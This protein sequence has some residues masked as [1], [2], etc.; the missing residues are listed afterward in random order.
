M[1]YES[2]WIFY[3][4]IL[5]IAFGSIMSFQIAYG[6][7]LYG[8]NAETSIIVD[9]RGDLNKIEYKMSGMEPLTW[10]DSEVKQYKHG[11]FFLKNPEIVIFGHPQG[12]DEYLL[13]VMTSNGFERFNVVS[14]DFFDISIASTPKE[15]ESEKISE[16]EIP[17]ESD[18]DRIL[19]EFEENRTES[20]RGADSTVDVI[21][22]YSGQVKDSF[23]MDEDFWLS[24]IVE[25][26]R[27]SRG[28][29]EGATVSY[30]ISRDGFV[31]R[32]DSA[33]TPQ[34]GYVKFKIDA[35]TYPEFYPK[36]CYTMTITTEWN[37][38]S[39]VEIE[40]FTM[41]MPSVW[42]PTLDWT[43]LE[44]WSYLPENYKKEPRTITYG[45][46]NCN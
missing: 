35:L 31:L 25:N 42:N 44:R 5:A 30:E 33:V 12:N 13:I 16:P 41:W 11:G 40:E 28:F 38:Y 27:T 6:E 21:I 1:K 3:G 24:G 23:K 26:V 32:E 36:F 17:V 2:D 45:D 14:D 7:I 15:I 9:F 18:T 4:M 46:E 34:S 22:N 29:L 19:R 20:A 10:Y 39:N 43:D 37:G 8:N